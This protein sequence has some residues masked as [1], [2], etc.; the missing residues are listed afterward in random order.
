MAAVSGNPADVTAV[1]LVEGPS[2]A[3]ALR[4]VLA[5][6]SGRGLGAQGVQVV[7]MG[8]VTNIGHH[9]RRLGSTG[10]RV[11]VAGLCDAAGDRFFRRALG[12]EGYAATTRGEM[13]GQGFFVC[14]PDL[15][16][17]LLTALGVETVERV[18]KREGER[19]LFTRFQQQPAQRRH[20][21]LAQMHRFAGT[22]SGQKVRL[23]AAMA[24][25]LEPDD[26]PR[27]LH[28]LLQFVSPAD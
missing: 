22:R 17:E 6:G 23:A 11:T 4:V 28:N 9:L 1:V 7:S 14:D 19:E 13:A 16:G 26:V 2:D 5:A 24:Q 8:G 25:A 15:E 27:P 21:T 20:P 12:N 3:A 18:L 10:R